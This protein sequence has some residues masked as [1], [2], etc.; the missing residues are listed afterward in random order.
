MDLESDLLKMISTEVSLD[1][2]QTIDADTDLLLTGLVDSRGVVMIVSW[3]E[4]RSGTEIDP[5]DVVL[6]NFQ[7][8][9]QMIDYME[10][11]Q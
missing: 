11:R 5:A 8:V 3:L 2:S 10:R 4:D 9:G 6:D 1:P 7:T